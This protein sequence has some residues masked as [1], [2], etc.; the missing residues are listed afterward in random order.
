MPLIWGRGDNRQCL[1]DGGEG[2]IVA[3]PE[4][5]PVDL[6]GDRFGR[7]DPHPRHVILADQVVAPTP[8]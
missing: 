3:H 1:R 5:V 2:H 8:N 7:G 6:A 4:K